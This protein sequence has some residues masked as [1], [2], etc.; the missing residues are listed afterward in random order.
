VGQGGGVWA[1][2]LV[3]VLVIGSAGD[4]CAGLLVVL[5]A[6]VSTPEVVVA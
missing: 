2:L 1:A 6:T 3:A 4:A 5:W